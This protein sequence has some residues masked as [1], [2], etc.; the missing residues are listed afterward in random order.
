MSAKRLLQIGL[1]G[2]VGALVVCAAV[3]WVLSSWFVSKLPEE[4]PDD[5]T[6]YI[7][8]GGG[9]LDESTDYRLEAGHFTYEEEVG[10]DITTVEFDLSEEELNYLWERLRVLR[11][12]HIQA[13]EEQDVYDRG[14]YNITV[15]YADTNIM[16]SDAGTSFING[17][18]AKRFYAVIEDVQM[19]IEPYL[20]GRGMNP[21]QLE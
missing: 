16:L 5:F 14:G 19:V 6:L 21:P 9:M 10:S 7:H 4:R 12:D 13:T 18:Q 11:F 20:I 3:M 2:I 17:G 15:S 8:E 1:A